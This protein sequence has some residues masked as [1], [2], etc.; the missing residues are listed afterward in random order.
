MEEKNTNDC[1]E[2]EHR[3]FLWEKRRPDTTTTTHTSMNGTERG[4][5]NELEA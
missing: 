2:C 4:G 5:A 1:L 3:V